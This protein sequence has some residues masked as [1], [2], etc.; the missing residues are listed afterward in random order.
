M[1]PRERARDDAA[2]R[3]HALDVRRSF[4]VQAPAGSGKTGLLIQRML[5]LLAQVERPEQILA[6]TFTR[7]SAAEMRARVLAALDDA[8]SGVPVA[9]ADAYS[10]QTRA[11]ALRVLAQD[12]RHDW[13]LLAH[14]A[15]L[16]MLTIDAVAATFARQAPLTTRLGAMP[17]FIDDA[18][19]HYRQAVSAAL[20]DANAD[21]PAWRPFLAHLDN[22]ARAVVALLAQMLAKRDQWRLA[23]PLGVAD[24]ALR[25]RLERALREEVEQALRTLT[26]RFPGPLVERL[27]EHLRHAARHLMTLPE[28][29]TPDD[30]DG[31]GGRRL[32]VALAEIAE[33]GG[34]PPATTD[35]L[36]L[37]R[38]MATWLLVKSE[39]RFREVFNKNAGFPPK[40][41]GDSDGNATAKAAM[42]A[43]VADA[44]RDPGLAAAL[45]AVHVLPP[46]RY[47]DD[48]WDFVAAT[49]AL[50]PQLAAHLQLVF[51]RAGESD[52]TEATLRALSALGDAEKPGELLLATDLRLAHILVDE[53]QD[54]S[55]AHAELLGRLTAGWQP[56]DGRTLFVVGD[57]MQSIYRF[58]AAEVG[59][60]LS[61]QAEGRVNDVPVDCLTL[62]R[63]FRSQA[64][65]V[66][67][68]NGV[69]A[70]VL[71]STSDATR[72]EVA[73]EP[74]LATRALADAPAP[75]VTL[76]HDAED[77]ARTVVAHVEQAQREGASEIAVLVRSR[78]H[79]G[80]ILPALR[81]AGI[82]YVAVE[83]EPL[84]ARLA[85]RDLL[86]LTRALLQPADML[87]GLALLRAPWCALTLADLLVIG[88][89]AQRSAVF[90]A[91]AAPEV[92]A[93]LSNDGA[94]RLARLQRAL[95]PAL[96]AR[97]RLPLVDRV[98][99]AWIALG[100]PA[101]GDGAL[102][103]AGAD[104]YFTELAA[105]ERG[106]DVPDWDAFVEAA[107]KLYAMP[108]HAPAGVVEVMTLHKAKGLE[109]DTVILPGLTRIAPKDDDPPLR[110]RLREREG[111]HRALLVAPL[112]ARV[113]ARQQPDPGFQYLR[114]LDAI[115]G[116]AEL[117]RLLYVGCTRSKRRLHLVAVPAIKAAT[118][119]SPRCWA[120][121]PSRSAWARLAPALAATLSA[122]PPPE[123]DD[124]GPAATAEDP[125]RA[126]S[127]PPLE[128]LPLA[129]GPPPL[130]AE[131][132]VPMLVTID[133]DVP[134]YDWAQATAGAIGTVAH[135]LLARVAQEGLA[136]WTIAHV[137]Q[138]QHQVLA[139]LAAEGLAREQRAAAA[140][141]VVA[142]VQRTLTDARGRWLFADRHEDA[143]SEYALAG[144][145]GD[146]I[147]HVSL[148]RTFV[149]EG[150]RW[151]VDF[152]TGMH[153]GGDPRGFLDREVARYRPQLERYARIMQHLDT[154]PLML[155]LYF[156]LVEEGWR[157]WRYE[158]VPATAGGEPPL[159]G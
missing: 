133:E 127:A 102:D 36:P 6:M 156:P 76:A 34:L 88:Q 29:A 49:L 103:L 21:D 18:T 56:D 8:M 154:R 3:T 121:P 132:P 98:R 139:E 39:G 15:R 119:K 111:G 73:Y 83:L 7:K 116:V 129:W 53:F 22:D 151:I 131:L 87:A 153:E 120:D 157:A 41:S 54:T 23:L 45:Y 43:W 104:R 128:R 159:S 27:R 71:G 82:R 96:A 46:S 108:E 42:S 109:F 77:E 140:A 47:G 51:A 14:P 64:P 72:G 100:G 97:G 20:A 146:R 92:L 57:P 12:V 145:V 79:L 58:R 48:A 52:F 50:L 152:K 143:H 94:A 91:I 9:V 25:D 101:C 55:W 150:M 148:D 118:T 67:W 149:A 28:P 130:P 78:S 32:G 62:S 136:T 158:P 61:A 75:T 99:A 59:I 66:D 117:G 68:V 138:Q 126:C 37:W 11:L 112:H 86:T 84:A 69:F 155:A 65:V 144:A 5:A 19:A 80:A 4:L 89:A 147:E 107:G 44:R 30:G 123:S 95:A 105:H 124:S 16:K 137:D 33:A 24:P 26:R 74:V 31:W 38:A 142:A 40:A 141:R 1:D 122:Q 70:Q 115:E 114:S 2:A 85:T 113:G 125:W 17:A 63:N 93:V 90:A 81:R 60:F 13:Q 110:W 10:A 134:P 135:R 106:G 35:A